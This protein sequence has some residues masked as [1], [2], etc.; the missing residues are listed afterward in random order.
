MIPED[1]LS[2]RRQWQSPQENPFGEGKVRS[3]T[4]RGTVIIAVYV[5]SGIVVG[6]DGLEVFDYPDGTRRRRSGKRK[7]LLV[8]ERVICA[9]CNVATVITTYGEVDFISAAETGAEQVRAQRTHLNFE[10]KCVLVAKGL[11]KKQHE[12]RQEIVGAFTDLPE[13]V[14]T[15][16]FFFGFE[17]SRARGGHVELAKTPVALAP[18]HFWRTSR[19]RLWVIG[20]RKSIEALLAGDSKLERYRHE[21]V[22][23]KA[24]IDP[25]SSSQVE[26]SARTYDFSDLPLSD[27]KELVKLLLRV[28]IESQLDLPEE[29]G[30]PIFLCTVPRNPRDKTAQENFA[31]PL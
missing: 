5:S 26:G 14:I 13:D 28:A 1:R 22:F 31:Q 20:P 10:Q 11:A 19:P 25:D 18:V 7:I 16:L 3:L 2:A 29:L 9:L 4:G 23:L 17:G 21:Q 24:N 6:A 12:L 27:A 8:D 15:R 30:G